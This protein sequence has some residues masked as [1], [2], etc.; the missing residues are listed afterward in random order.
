MSSVC[1]C[2]GDPCC[3]HSGDV[4]KHEPERS[5]LEVWCPEMG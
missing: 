3:N 2:G 5:G 4:K 1:M